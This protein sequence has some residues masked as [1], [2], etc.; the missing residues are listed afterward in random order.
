MQKY[1]ELGI[2]SYILS[3]GL[4]KLDSKESF[5]HAIVLVALD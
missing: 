2:E 3:V 1:S 4:E 5:T